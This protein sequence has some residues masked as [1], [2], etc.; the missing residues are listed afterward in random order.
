MSPLKH[1]LEVKD[2]EKPYENYNKIN[3][4]L[5]LGNIYAAKSKSFLRKHKIRAVVNCSKVNDIPNYY[6]LLDKHEIEYFRVPVDDS[7]KQIDFEKMLLL[8]PSAVEFIHKHVDILK[9][10]IFVHCWEGKERSVTVVV[11]YL[12]KYHNM[13]P[14]EACKYVL[15]KRKES[16]HYGLSV[17][18]ES[19]ILKYY[20]QISSKIV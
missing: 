13:S 4:R 3:S 16:F 14:I 10:N 7:L 9:R 12:M 17:N 1:G 15:K 2:E 18:F 8:L 20:K 11:C 19:T 5:Y 6:P